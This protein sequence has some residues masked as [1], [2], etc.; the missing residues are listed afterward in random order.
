MFPKSNN[1]ITYNPRKCLAI[2]VREDSCL[3]ID[4]QRSLANFSVSSSIITIAHFHQPLFYSTVNGFQNPTPFAYWT[5]GFFLRRYLNGWKITQQHLQVVVTRFWSQ[6]RLNALNQNMLILLAMLG[7]LFHRVNAGVWGK[8]TLLFRCYFSPTFLIWAEEKKL[9][10][11]G[12]RDAFQRER[13][14]TFV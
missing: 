8:Y 4:I 11:F 9:W 10:P 6:W 5:L 1:F 7:L 12:M 3:D 14:Q 13:F 2:T